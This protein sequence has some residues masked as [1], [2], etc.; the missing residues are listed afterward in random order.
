MLLASTKLGRVRNPLK[1]RGR[2]NG[3]SVPGAGREAESRRVSRGNWTSLARQVMSLRR[4]PLGNAMSYGMDC[5][6]GASSSRLARINREEE[7]TVFGSAINLPFPDI[8]EAWGVKP[9][10]G[11]FRRAIASKVP[12]LI[13]SGTIDGRTP[14]N[15]GKCLE[16]DCPD[17]CT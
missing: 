6:S 14:V 3:R 13:I 9:L 4:R 17:P 7:R 5:A 12:V 1:D 15:N 2:R 10:P 16:R 8:C 11:G